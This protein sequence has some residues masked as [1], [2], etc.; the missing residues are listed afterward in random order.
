V[1]LVVC[2]DSHTTQVGD[3]PAA[4]AAWTAS[5][6]LRVTAAANHRLLSRAVSVWLRPPV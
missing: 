4:E 3:G 2:G 1:H 5:R 6:C